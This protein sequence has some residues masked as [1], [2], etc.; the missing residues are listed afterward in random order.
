MTLEDPDVQ[1]FLEKRPV[2]QVISD[3]SPEMAARRKFVPELCDAFTGTY[4]AVHNVPG[5]KFTIDKEAERQL[6]EIISNMVQQVY[7]ENSLTDDYREKYTA[8]R[9]IGIVFSGGPAPGGHNVIAGLLS[10]GT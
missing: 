1:Q 8:C 2:K 4:T 7:R 5:F 6:P 3:V 9:N 10:Q